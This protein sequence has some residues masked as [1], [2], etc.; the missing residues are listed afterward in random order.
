[1]VEND[2]CTLSHLPLLIIRQPDWVEIFQDI[3]SR[4]I[5]LN[6]A[7]AIEAYHVA[8]IEFADKLEEFKEALLFSSFQLFGTHRNHEVNIEVIVV[9]LVVLSNRE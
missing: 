5:L 7:V 9:F 1:M 8:C 3:F 4:V 2:K 6:F